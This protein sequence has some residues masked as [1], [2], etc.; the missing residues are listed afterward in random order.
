MCDKRKPDQ[1]PPQP[2]DPTDEQI[3]TLIAIARET[4]ATAVFEILADVWQAILIDDRDQRLRAVATILTRV[5][6]AQRREIN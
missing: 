6:A 5:E 3:A 1:D 2:L 4:A